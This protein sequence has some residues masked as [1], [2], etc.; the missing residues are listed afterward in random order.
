MILIFDSQYD[1][2]KTSCLTSIPVSSL[3]AP[4]TVTTLTSQ[5]FNFDMPTRHL[6]LHLHSFHSVSH[7]I[8]S[9]LPLKPICVL[10]SS[11]S[12]L[13]LPCSRFSEYMYSKCVFKTLMGF[14]A[15]IIQFSWHLWEVVH[16]VVEKPEDDRD[17]V[18]LPSWLKA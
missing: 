5:V 12:G 9:I 8:L 3:T 15:H 10:L 7:S 18:T 4:V 1:Y 13:G 16:F 2:N 14:L 17:T 11:C 6:C